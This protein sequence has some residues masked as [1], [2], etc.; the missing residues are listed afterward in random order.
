[1]VFEF[2]VLYLCIINVVSIVVTVYDKL[3]AIH[4]RWRVSEKAL[5]IL[6]AIGGSIGMYL[7]MLIIRHK[8]KHMRF[9][10][11]IPLIFILEISLAIVI[12]VLLK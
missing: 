5:F 3:A 2:L 6:S 8:T 7:T 9:M 1:M 4:S 12:L 10:I 11:G